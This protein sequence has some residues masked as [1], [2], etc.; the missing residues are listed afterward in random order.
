MGRKN[1][2]LIVVALVLFA[3]GV[4]AASNPLLMGPSPGL[5]VNGTGAAQSTTTPSTTPTPTLGSSTTG[6]LGTTN[7][8][9]GTTT[10]SAGTA[11]ALQPTPGTTG[12]G[13]TGTGIP[14]TGTPTATGATTTTTAGLTIDQIVAITRTVQPG[15]P[16][17]AFTVPAGQQLVITDVLITNPGTTPACG[18]A[19]NPAGAVTNGP[20]TNA[21]AGVTPP[22]TTIAETGTGELCVPAQTSLDLGLTT[23]LEF[24]AGQGV[25]LANTATAAP[26]TPAA[27]GPLHYHLRGFLITPTGV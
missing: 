7:G 2:I 27:I 9:L 14:T 21:T 12:T 18:A 10:P 25:Q 8:T 23:G 17:T 24:S 26:D 15:A 5:A 16:V 13:T 11:T 20:A 4:A 3:A 22:V 19:V 1:S 6:T